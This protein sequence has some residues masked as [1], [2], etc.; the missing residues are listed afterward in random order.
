MRN[1]SSGEFHQRD[2]L[3]FGLPVRVLCPMG[4]IAR[5]SRGSSENLVRLQSLDLHFPRC[6][7]TNTSETKD[8]QML[9]VLHAKKFC[10]RISK[11][12]A[13]DKKNNA[14]Q[15]R[16]MYTLP[17]AQNV[18]PRKMNANQ[19]QEKQSNLTL[20]AFSRLSIL[21]LTH[22]PRLTFLSFSFSF[23]RTSFQVAGSATQPSS[24]NW[25]DLPRTR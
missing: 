3:P 21:Y 16:K 13:Y 17:T 6:I 22:F 14:I 18:L 2:Y 19:K 15:V 23:G 10:F 5:G 7:L 11:I 1:H 12:N 9:R 24:P 8:L 20:R 25:Y 4:P